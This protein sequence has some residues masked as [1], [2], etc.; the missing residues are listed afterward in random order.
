MIMLNRNK[1]VLHGVGEPYGTKFRCKTAQRINILG[2]SQNDRV[3]LM[4]SKQNDG[5]FVTG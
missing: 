2:C 5:G 3:S 1:G 4:L